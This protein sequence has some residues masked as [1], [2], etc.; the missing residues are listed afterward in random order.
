MD[1]ID[2]PQIF[3]HLT[4]QVQG[5]PYDVRW[6][7]YSNKLVLLGQTPKMEG[8]LKFYKLEKQNLKEIYSGNF[9]KGLKTCSWNFYDS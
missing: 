1:S 9:G 5:T 3:E 7:P 2:A 4:V 6:L 8:I